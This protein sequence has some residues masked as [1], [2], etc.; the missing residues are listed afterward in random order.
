MNIS[1]HLSYHKI[2]LLEGTKDIISQVEFE[3]K[4][5]IKVNL[6]AANSILKG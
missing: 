6:K 3:N 4:G 2:L 5:L 1:T